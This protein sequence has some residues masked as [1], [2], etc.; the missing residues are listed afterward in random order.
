MNSINFSSGAALKL[1]QMLSIADIKDNPMFPK[2]LA[3]IFD[4]VR[5]GADYMPKWQ[6]Q[7]KLLIKCFL[8]SGIFVI[9]GILIYSY[10]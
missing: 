10:C 6:V 7:N 8:L 1:G 4:R 5:Q 2:D 9:W 3:K